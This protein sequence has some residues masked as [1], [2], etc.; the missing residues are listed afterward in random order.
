V[1]R[2][3]QL[4]EKNETRIENKRSEM[5]KAQSKVEGMINT[6]RRRNMI[7]KHEAKQNTKGQMIIREEETEWIFK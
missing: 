4:S 5:R 3:E 1:I 6:R 7:G 2:K